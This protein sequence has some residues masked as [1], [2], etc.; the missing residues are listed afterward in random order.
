MVLFH[1]PNDLPQPSA[2][3][4]ATVPQNI[5]QSKTPH[6][7]MHLHLQ[8]VQYVHLQYACITRPVLC[9]RFLM[10]VHACEFGTEYM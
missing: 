3:I 4:H 6:F 9:S 8:Y 10:I 7:N 5:G 2:A 1:F